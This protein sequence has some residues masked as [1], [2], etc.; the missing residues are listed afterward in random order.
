M[1]TQQYNVLEG[2]LQE[3]GYRYQSGR[4]SSE[5]HSF[6]KPF[7]K[8]HNPYDS[9]GRS[10]YQIFFK[11]WD[12]TKYPQRA[13]GDDYGVSVVIAVS[14]TVN[15]RVDMEIPYRGTPISYFEELAE[16][17]YEWADAHIKIDEQ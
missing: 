5:D 10:C 14:R 4:M 1:T 17:F 13:E 2:L 12:W 8:Y 3:K 7:R 15:D 16:S 6:Y 11:V 9:E